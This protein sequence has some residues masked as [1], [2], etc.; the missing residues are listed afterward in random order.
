V[1]WPIVW[2]SIA[3]EEGKQRQV[4]REMVTWESLRELATFRAGKGCAVSLYVDLDPSAAP[5]PADAET[6]FHSLLARAQK[7]VDTQGYD[8]ERK[9]A[10]VRDLN[11]IRIW[12]EV[13]FD[14]DGSHGVALFASSLDGLWRTLSLTDAVEDRI[15]LEHDLFLTP[16]VPLVGRGDGALVAVVGRERGQVFRLRSGRLHEI[17]DQSE[18]Q[19][20]RHDQGGWSQARYQR[21]IEKL[22]HDHLKTV[23]TE[24]G[25]RLRGPG[26]LEMVVVAPHELRGEFESA[27]SPEARDAIVGWTTA[28]AHATPPEVLEVVRPILDE[29]RARAR[30]KAV[31]RWQAEAGRNGRAAAGWEQ[32]VEAATEGRVE[33]LLVQPRASREAH[34]C[35]TCER[36]SANPGSCPVD[37]TELERVDDALDLVVHR[38]LAFGGSVVQ[39][40]EGAL[41]E[42]E[43]I[44]ALLRF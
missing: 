26:K 42:H 34:R 8:H 38:V 10:L 23:G 35:P 1:P 15:R 5:T 16:L 17:V 43:G 25:R 21:H 37:G 33:L 14:R 29:T 3:P 39:V 22:V 19:P 41:A 28:E 32:T 4:A 40:E 20:G 27:L 18:E 12:W 9:Q 11:R 44:G 30:K 24:L 6:R 2:M 7:L 13:D 31:E 36:G